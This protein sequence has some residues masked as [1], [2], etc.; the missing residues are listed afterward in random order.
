MPTPEGPADRSFSKAYGL[1]GFRVG[2]GI[3]QPAL[4]HAI[5]GVGVPFS[6]TKAAEAGALAALNQPDRLRAN[7]RE[8]NAE[9]GR[10]AAGLRRLG[11]PVLAG[12]GNFV[13]LPL[14]GDLSHLTDPLAATGILVKTYPGHGIR[15]SV[16]TAQHT[17]QLITVLSRHLSA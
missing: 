9:R 10:M 15:V 16:G 2:Y 13:W 17:D 14:A 12:C 8:I 7:V 1:A 3:A 6:L 11:L 4:A 5:T